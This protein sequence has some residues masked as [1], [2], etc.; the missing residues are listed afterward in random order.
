MGRYGLSL[1]VAVITR[2]VVLVGLLKGF[3]GHFSFGGQEGHAAAQ[4]CVDSEVVVVVEA[5]PSLDDCQA[6]VA[7]VKH[8]FCVA[9]ELGT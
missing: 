9:G 1:L 7:R 6:L 2:W 3:H 4:H 5:T 8:N